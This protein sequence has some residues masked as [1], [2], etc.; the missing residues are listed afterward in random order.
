MEEQVIERHFYNLNPIGQLTEYPASTTLVP[1]GFDKE[2]NGKYHP[3]G[4]GVGYSTS[5]GG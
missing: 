2:G 3:W 4:V 5:K 1:I